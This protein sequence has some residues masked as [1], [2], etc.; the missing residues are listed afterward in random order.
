M[1]AMSTPDPI[2]LASAVRLPSFAGSSKS[3]A[4]PIV[5]PLWSGIRVLVAAGPAG[6][7]MFDAGEALTTHGDL[8]EAFAATTAGTCDGVI[9]EAWLTRQVA[10]GDVGVYTGP[11]GDLP[12]TGAFIGQV[13][14]GSRSSRLRQKTEDLEAAQAG[15]DIP[16]EE[17]VDLV[18]VDLLWL[19][20]QWLLEVPLQERKRILES[21]VPAGELVRPGIH[22]RPPIDAWVSSWRAQ[23]FAGLTFRA[24]NSR[25]RPGEAAT[26]WATA[27]MPRR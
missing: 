16:A 13:L 20:G 14:L 12:S 7:A 21:V 4:D 15:R 17:P 19:D 27:S 10:V 1:V 3:F 23:G 2:P 25:Y 26:D 5:E 24:A 9:V 6:A 18:V 11:D 8:L 22:V